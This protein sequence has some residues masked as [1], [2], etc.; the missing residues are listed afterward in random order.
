M[1]EVAAGLVE[2]SRGDAKAVRPH[3]G[4]ASPSGNLMAS[5]CRTAGE[6]AHL[7]LADGHR[8]AALEDLHSSDGGESCRRGGRIADRQPSSSG[9][10]KTPAA[11]LHIGGDMEVDG[12][13]GAGGGGARL[14]HLS[15]RLAGSPGVMW[16]TSGR[17][18]AISRPVKR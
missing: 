2:K 4:G 14:A 7:Q 10:P 15:S 9:A 13:G 12:V 6:E 5:L 17:Q 3:H 1:F 8:Q 11:C 16:E 18:A